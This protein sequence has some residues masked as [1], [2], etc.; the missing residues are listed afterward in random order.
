M[1]V[2]ISLAGKVA[3][4]TGGRRQLGRAQA[5]RLAE[6]G[7]DVCVA[8]IAIDDDMQT[9]VATI[10][11]LGRRVLPVVCDVSKRAQVEAMVESCVR[12]LGSIDVLVNNAGVSSRMS[13]MDVTDDEWDDVLD[14]NLKGV[15]L[16]TQYAAKHMIRQNR[17]GAV[18]NM[19]S[20]TGLNANVSRG[21]YSVSKAGVIMATKLF[22]RELGAHKITV[23][24][25]APG[26]TS[27]AKI[28]GRNGVIFRRGPDET[29]KVFSKLAL[30]REGEPVDYAN[31]IVFLASDL[32]A[33]ITGMTIAIDGGFTIP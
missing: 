2:E 9:T 6:C 22:A 18:V 23:N 7:A 17:G 10:E 13:L 19:S 25:I 14:I 33:Y 27:T 5:V 31:T 20:S 4:V 16:C 3:I 12:E 8:D 29:A 1:S 21:P 32:G 15:V 24:A 28:G 30:Q 26:F 11:K